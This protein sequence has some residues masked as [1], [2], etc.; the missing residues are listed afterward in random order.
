MVSPG[1]AADAR[2][3]LIAPVMQKTWVWCWAA[4]G[5]M[6][7]TH[8]GVGNADPA[9]SFQCGI[10]ESLADVDT[11][12]CAHQCYRPECIAA[13]GSPAFLKRMLE[14]YPKR[15]SLS[16]RSV[17]PRLRAVYR[18]AALSKAALRE[19]IDAERPVVAGINPYGIER[20]VGHSAHVALV[21]G[22]EDDGGTLI[23][24]DPGPYPILD[25]A[26]RTH[27]P[28]R[29]AGGEMLRKGQ[30]RIAYTAFLNEFGWIETLTVQ[31]DGTF[32]E[33]EAP[34]YCCTETGRLGPYPYRGPD[35]RAL[36]AGEQC[37]A[38]GGSGLVR[39]LACY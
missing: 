8:Y 4:V 15:G 36:A 2:R 1:A 11:S 12:Q 6:V 34:N 31:A 18:D 22:Y 13:G 32:T 9:A 7:F 20:P 38:K 28:Y 29:A 17:Q 25:P 3:L 37:F 16:L 19:E 39:G 23:V 14:V 5:E 30:Y 10:V 27:N 21:T 24:N 26:A 33:P 35:G